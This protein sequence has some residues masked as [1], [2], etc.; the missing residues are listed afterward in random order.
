MVMPPFRLKEG[1]FGYRYGLLISSHR[2]LVSTYPMFT[3]ARNPLFGNACLMGRGT[4]S[5]VKIMNTLHVGFI[6]Q[7]VH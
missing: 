2:Q 4:E 1:L 3:L 5:A 6:V 7:L